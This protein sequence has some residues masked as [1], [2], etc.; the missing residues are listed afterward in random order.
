MTVSIR[1][2]KRFL[3]GR[4]QL[5]TAPTQEQVDAFWYEVK[6]ALAEPLEAGVFYKNESLH[7][8]ERPG[9]KQRIR[10][11][12]A[13][14]PDML[15]GDFADDLYLDE[16]QLCDEDMWELVG[17]P[18]LLDNDG[19]ALFVYTPPSLHS[20]SLSKA[21]DP[22]H[23]ARMFAQAQADTSGRWVA[24][25][26][27]SR[28]N[29]YISTEALG[30]L[31]RDM[32]RLAFRQEIMAEDVDAAPDAL[33]QRDLIERGRVSATPPL[34]RIVIGVDPPGGVTEAGI[35]TVG[36]AADG[37]LYV[38]A[39]N[40]LRASPD[41]W[42]GEVLGAYS[43]HQADRIVGESNFGG[44]MV[45]STIR[46]AAQ[47]RGL[48]VSYKAVSASR[49]KAVRA[50]PV[51]ALYEQGRVHHVGQFPVLEEEMVMWVPGESRESPNRL[52]ALVWA[53]T[54]LMP[55]GGGNVRFL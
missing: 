23:A 5:Y 1:A 32:S 45:E 2:V 25:H 33:W 31:S 21:R 15:R 38:L 29:P 48:T 4:R 44:D 52:D 47:S 14:N 28:E 55:I 35:V 26:W 50:E 20:R 36:K 13:Y 9:T 18:M 42:A 46:Q 10:A 19:D 17:Q 43:R 37:H 53:C 7:L 41:G 27:A 22:R 40:S 51:V 54:E 12:T 6:Q 30:Q 34:A 16:W 24:F 49:G 11:K 3:A 39:D 8:I